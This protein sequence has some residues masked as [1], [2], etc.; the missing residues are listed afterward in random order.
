MWIHLYVAYIHTILQSFFKESF[1]LAVGNRFERA[2]K[3]EM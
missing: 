1:I 2:R 3:I